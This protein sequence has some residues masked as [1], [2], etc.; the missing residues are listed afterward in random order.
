MRSIRISES[1]SATS[2][3]CAV[4]LSSAWAGTFSTTVTNPSSTSS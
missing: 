2:T 3:L 1:S 4:C